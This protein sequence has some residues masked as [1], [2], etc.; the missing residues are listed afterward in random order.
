M[1]WRVEPIGTVRSGPA[2]S[3]VCRQ[4]APV[5]SRYAIPDRI[6]FFRNGW[7]LDEVLASHCRLQLRRVAPSR[8]GVRL[9]TSLMSLELD[10]W[11]APK[12]A[13]RFW[14][15]GD[16]P[17]WVPALSQNGQIVAIASDNIGV[18]F[19]HLDRNFYFMGL[20]LP[21]EHWAM[22]FLGAGY[23]KLAPKRDVDAHALTIHL[24]ASYSPDELRIP[25]ATALRVAPDRLAFG[26]TPVAPLA[27]RG[28]RCLHVVMANQPG[29]FP[30]VLTLQSAEQDLAIAARLARSLGREVALPLAAASAER[31][32][33]TP[34]GDVLPS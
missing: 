15:D 3:V 7:L 21:P 8:F 11:T 29:D 14:T 34:Q 20:F 23:L 33:V 6:T 26:W 17:G 13:L 22:H 30:L 18:H 2:A 4:T 9:V 31:A 5:S 28:S 25:L 16:A 10:L 19:E 24:S 1:P 12:G 32:I 27:A